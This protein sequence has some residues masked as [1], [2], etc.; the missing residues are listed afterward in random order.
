M[1]AS[2]EFT[3]IQALKRFGLNVAS[4]LEARSLAV[5]CPACPQPE[6]N[7]DPGWRDRRR[8]EW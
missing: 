4:K 3:Y 2:R 1:T 5:F 7:M 8:S 6:I